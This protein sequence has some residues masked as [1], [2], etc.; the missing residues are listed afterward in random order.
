MKSIQSFLDDKTFSFPNVPTDSSNTVEEFYENYI[1]IT[2]QKD[3]SIVEKWH[4]MLVNYSKDPDAILLS[5]LYESQRA[6]DGTWDNRCGM[7]TTMKDNFSY[8]FASNN[9][10]RIIYSMVYA[11]YVPEYS[12]FKNMVV[13]H[14]FSLY[15]NYGTTACIR[16]YSAFRTKAYNRKFYTP[17]WY[18]AHIVSVNDEGFFNYPNANIKKILTLGKLS[19]WQLFDNIFKRKLDYS[20]SDSERQIIIAHFLRFVDPINYF[21]VPNGY[22]LNGKSIG[23]DPKIVGYM[24]KLYSDLYGH[25]FLNFLD[26]SLA[27]KNS[28]PQK[29]L[30]DL[31]KEN[32]GDIEITDKKKKNSISDSDKA[33]ILYGY[34]FEKNMSLIKLETNVLGK[35]FRGWKSKEI[36]NDYN[37]DTSRN[38]TDKGRYS[39]LTV[40]QS[41]KISK[42]VD[43]LNLLQFIKN[44]LMM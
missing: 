22:N 34:L 4:N 29:K 35:D 36:L 27:D 21:L 12:D 3:S 37:I 32:L 10:A 18:L 8:A 24:K 9:F 41:I 33:K 26:L 31:G 7:E 43:E 28:I 15:S 5:R 30:Y 1:K 44:N 19:D 39:G 20:F 14:I 11:G 25:T 16:Q 23:E 6:K 17:G 13:N 38:S 40:E 2:L 42:N